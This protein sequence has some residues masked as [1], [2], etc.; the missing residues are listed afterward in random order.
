MSGRNSRRERV[1]RDVDRDA[2]TCSALVTAPRHGVRAVTASRTSRTGMC[3]DPLTPF[4]VW[5]AAGARIGA[6]AIA[7]AW[8]LGDW[9][10]FGQAKYGRRY[11]AAV[12]ATV[13]DSQT[14]RNYA[15]VARRFKLSRRRD[16][17]RFQHHAEVCGPGDGSKCVNHYRRCARRG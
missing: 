7:S 9:L 10:A 13:L 17:L 2:R 6:D 14:L 1:A 15:V 16:D 11:E 5:E 3:F 4:D 12:A 8:W